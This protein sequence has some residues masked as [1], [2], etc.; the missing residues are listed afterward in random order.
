MTKSRAMPSDRVT[1]SLGDRRTVRSHR[2]GVLLDLH[3]AVH[4][5]YCSSRPIPA[6][7]NCS[8]IASATDTMQ[9]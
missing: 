2:A 5:E 7:R 8:V 6:A 9:W 1:D 3:A 4:V